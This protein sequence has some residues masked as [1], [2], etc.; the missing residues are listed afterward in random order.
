MME[1]CSTYNK[2]ARKINRDAYANKLGTVA[3]RKRLF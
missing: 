3:N 1:F 2:Y